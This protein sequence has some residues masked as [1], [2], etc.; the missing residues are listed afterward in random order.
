MKPVFGPHEDR[1]TATARRAFSESRTPAE[2][3]CREQEIA[4]LPDVEWRGRR[5]QTIQCKGETGKGPHSVNVPES[6]LWALI[7]VRQYRCAFHR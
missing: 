1:Q 4:A 5:L 6:L 7:D 3:K 2:V